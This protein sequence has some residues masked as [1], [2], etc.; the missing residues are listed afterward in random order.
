MLWGR[1]GGA[2][3]V[4]VITFGKIEEKVIVIILILAIRD[5]WTI[6]EARGLIAVHA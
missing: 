3:K 6:R 2:L 5:H 4:T 1:S